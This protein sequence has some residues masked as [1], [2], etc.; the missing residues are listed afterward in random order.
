MSRTR[1]PQ[2][3]LQPAT[4]ATC[5]PSLIRV[6]CADS[7]VPYV[8]H[9][10]SILVKWL[11]HI[12][13]MTHSYLSHN[14]FIRVAW[15]IHVCHVTHSYVS[16]APFIRNTLLF[17]TCPSSAR[18][19]RSMRFL[20][21]MQARGGR[22]WYRMWLAIRRERGRHVWSHW[23]YCSIAVFYCCGGGIYL[24]VWGIYSFCLGYLL[25]CQSIY[26]FVWIFPVPLRIGC[27][28]WMSDAWWGGFG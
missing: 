16:L 21:T 9:D 13:H 19:F 25:F 20:H 23:V 18:N 26:C 17:H 7:C 15:L 2:F 12:G 27:G 8:S 10:S 3:H 11:M 6:T 28:R 5:S 22:K 4:S 14:S 1:P 24:F